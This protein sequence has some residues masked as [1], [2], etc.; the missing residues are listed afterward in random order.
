MKIKGKMCSILA[1]PVAGLL[2]FIAVSGIW[3]GS[4][5]SSLKHTLDHTFLPVIKEDLPQIV[6]FNASI[7]S[8]LNADRDAYQ[9]LVAELQA[10][11]NDDPARIDAIVKESSLNIKQVRERSEEAS[12]MF[13]PAMK[14]QYDTFLTKYETWRRQSQKVVEIS[15]GLARE[16]R[17]R[18]ELLAA[19]DTVFTKMRTCI[20]ELDGL[21]EK[22][23]KSLNRTLQ[24]E[25]LDKLYN[26]QTLILNADRDA[27]QAYLAQIQSVYERDSNT[28][29]KLEKENLTNINQ[30][31]QRV[32][33]ASANF[34]KN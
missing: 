34:D 1:V 31:E 2:V 21:V 13:S 32:N 3:L 8:L 12:K 18:Q 4:T 16:Y 25:Q 23:L 9:A 15:S 20:D 11:N 10:M 6:Q 19:N 26:A 33:E 27:Y 30:V 22:R 29:V 28:M 7:S 5:S 17:K 24:Y 14:G